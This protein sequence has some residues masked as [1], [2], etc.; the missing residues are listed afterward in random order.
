MSKILSATC[1]A[2]GK[3]TVE[4]QVVSA[5]VLSEGKK[6]SS[7]LLVIDESTLYYLPSNASD[8]HDLISNV[9]DL[10]QKLEDVFTQTVVAL[11][12]LDGVTTTPGSASAAIALVTTKNALVATAATTFLATKDT[13]K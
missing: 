7:G 3:V 6:A 2:S 5:S 10:V 12:A 11:S 1:D 4:G 13:L 8:I 9:K